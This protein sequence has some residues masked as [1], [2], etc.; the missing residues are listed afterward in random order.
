MAK[1]V[2]NGAAVR[3]GIDHPEYSYQTEVAPAV[4]DSLANDLD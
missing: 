4:R 2:K 1:T 3:M